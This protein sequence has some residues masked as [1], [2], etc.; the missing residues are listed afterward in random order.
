MKS[1]IERRSHLRAPLKLDFSLKMPKGEIKGKTSDISICGLSILLFSKAPKIHDMCRVTLTLPKGPE[2]T[3]ACKKVWSG[4][5]LN[6]ETLFD[7][8][9]VRFTKI[10]DSERRI[11]LTLVRDYYRSHSK[12]FFSRFKQF[13]RSK[14]LQ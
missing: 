13:V 10:S 11:L 3:I 4:K 8:M 1:G 6:N 2:M 5:V 7:A 9:G 14:R 12:R